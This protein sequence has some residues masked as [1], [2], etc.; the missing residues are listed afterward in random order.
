MKAASHGPLAD[1]CVIELGQLIVGAFKDRP[2]RAK[3][4]SANTRDIPVLGVALTCEDHPVP[5]DDQINHSIL[6][7]FVGLY[8][9]VANEK[10]IEMQARMEAKA[11]SHLAA[12]NDAIG[13]ERYDAF[14]QILK[15]MAENLRRPDKEQVP[16]RMSANCRP[17]DGG[18][19]SPLCS[20][21]MVIIWDCPRE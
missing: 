13:P 7:E 20:P 17:L 12:L 9:R 8:L 3:G 5:E 21:R 4:A 14:I 15:D 2:K 10:G 19:P 1:L 11:N 6:H 18:Q 16:A